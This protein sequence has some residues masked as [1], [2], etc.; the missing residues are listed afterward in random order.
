[1]AVSLALR[2]A[3]FLLKGIAFS[4]RS[5]QPLVIVSESFPMPVDITLIE[6]TN[7]GT[8]ANPFNGPIYALPF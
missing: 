4:L 5:T 3:R 1:M 2:Y 6:S 8:S 7:I